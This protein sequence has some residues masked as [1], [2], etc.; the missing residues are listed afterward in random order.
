MITLTESKVKFFQEEHKYFLGEKQLKGITGTLVR[1]AFPDTY[2]GIPEYILNNAAD[3]GSMVHEQLELFNTIFNSDPSQWQGEW[4]PEL[5]NFSQMMKE[6]SLSHV[7]SEY[8]VTDGENFASSI[9]AVFTDADG[10]I[11]LVDYKTTSQ[12]Y[13]DHVSLQLSIYAKF[14]EQM[15]PGL[16]VSNIVCIWLHGNDYKYAELPRV[17]NKKIDE[18]IRAYL[19]NDIYYVYTLDTPKS[20]S[21]LES[22]YITLEMQVSELSKQLDDV[23]KQMLM[24]MKEEK[25]KSYKT[26]FGSYSFVPGG[27]TNKFDTTKFKKEHA[28]MYN[29][30][31]KES[32]TKDSIRITLKKQ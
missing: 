12:L 20:F 10:G 30:Y 8:L 28:D 24:R 9:D 4:T 32:T 7:A 14:F 6:H 18:L 23:K 11:I 15:N 21:D 27:K 25:A 17:D 1:K 2:S 26:A 31:L 3:R 13:Y 5:S 29:Q 16:K 22:Q 19:D